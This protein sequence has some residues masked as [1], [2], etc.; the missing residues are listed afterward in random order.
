MLLTNWNCVRRTVLPRGLCI[1]LNLI[2]FLHFVNST[3][4]VFSFNANAKTYVYILLIQNEM[5]HILNFV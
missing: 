5:S 4:S 3:Y 2:R 1:Y